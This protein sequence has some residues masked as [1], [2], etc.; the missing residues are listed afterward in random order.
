MTYSFLNKLSQL[1]EIHSTETKY[2]KTEKKIIRQPIQMLRCGTNV[3]TDFYLD[4]MDWNNY[5]ELAFCL[6]DTIFINSKETGSWDILYQNNVDESLGYYIIIT[7]LAFY[8]D[9]YLIFGD[10]NGVLRI[11]EIP[12]RKI[13]FEQQIHNDRINKIVTGKNMILTGSK[14]SCV[15]LIDP[16]QLKVVNDEVVI[17]DSELCG[18]TLNTNENYF[19]SGS[20]DGEVKVIDMRFGH[21]FHTHQHNAAVKAMTFSP[22]RNGVLITGGGMTDRTL[23]MY[24]VESGELMKVHHSHSQIT[25]IE[26]FGNELI[27]SHGNPNNSLDFFDSD[28]F[29]LLGESTIHS[30]MIVYMKMSSN[31]Y[32]ATFDSDSQLNIWKLYD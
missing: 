18:M 24:N 1:C 7:S 9:N 5:G 22:H 21:E 10:G 19:A 4:I 3:I 32:L 15:K 31:G 13:I 20:N 26:W 6:T 28:Q 16:I 29:I 30:D 17:H 14:D 8:D 23:K 25:G 27:V 12:T 11:L 2:I